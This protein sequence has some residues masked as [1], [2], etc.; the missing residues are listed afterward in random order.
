MIFEVLS[1]LIARIDTEEKR[2]AYFTTSDRGLCACESALRAA[3]VL[4]WS[5]EVLTASI[6]RAADTRIALES[7][8]GA[9]TF[10]EIYEVTNSKP[11]SD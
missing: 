6:L 10:G 3:T 4:R 2:F 7:A 9:L 11:D 8:G 1:E 5:G